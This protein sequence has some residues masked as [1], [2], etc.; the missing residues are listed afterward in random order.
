MIRP[1]S[2][3]TTM[4]ATKKARDLFLDALDRAPAD[5]S[6]YLDETCG[7]DAALRQR[8]EALLRANDDP[9]AFLSEAKPVASDAAPLPPDRA[10][11]ATSAQ[12]P[13]GQPP[14]EDYGDPTA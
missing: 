13:G 9:R 14:T 10:G 3:G 2:V 7:D 12:V 5:R 11:D 1:R 6:A 4:A 8:V